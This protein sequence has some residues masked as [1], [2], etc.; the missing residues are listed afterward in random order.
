[1]DADRKTQLLSWLEEFSTQF[2][3]TPKGVSHLA[4]YAANRAEGR[5]NFDRAHA[6][7]QAGGDITD[8]VLDTL[9]PHAETVKNRTRGAWCHVAPAITGDIR[10]FFENAEWA[11]REDWPAIAQLLY[12]FFSACDREPATVQQR[13]VEFSTHPLRKGFK[14]AFLS[15]LLNALHPDLFPIVNKKPLLLLTWLHGEKFTPSVESYP[16]TAKFLRDLAA[17]LAEPLARTVAGKA[18]PPVGDVLDMFA[19]WLLTEKKYAA[20][21]GEDEP[22]DETDLHAEAVAE[23]APGHPRYWLFAA[24]RRAEAWPLFRDHKVVAI[25]WDELGDLRGFSSRDAL[26][27]ALRD[28]RSEE[29]DRD[30][31][32]ASL[33]CWEFAHAVSVGDFVVAKEGRDR[34]LGLGRV[35]GG[36]EFLPQASGYKHRL[37]VEW[38]RTGEWH[39]T[40]AKLPTKTLTEITDPE[41]RTEILDAINAGAAPDKSVAPAQSATTPARHW[42]MNFNPTVFDIEATPDGHREPYTTHNDNGRPRNLPAA[43][44]AAQPGDFVIGYSTAPRMRACVLC[45]ITKA[46][47]VAAG[48]EVIEFERVRALGRAVSREEMLADERLADVGALR[49]PR[50]SLFPLSADQFAAIMD[51]ADVEPLKPKIYNAAEALADLFTTSARLEELRAQLDRKKNLVLQGPPGV[52]KTFIARRLAWLLIGA[53]DD[54]R[55]EM[56]QFHPSLSYEDFVLGLRPGVMPGGQPGFVLRPGVFHRFCRRAQGDPGRPYVFIIDEINRGNLAKIFGELLML[57]E[58]DKR[59]EEHA[60]PLAYGG[61]EDGKFFLPANLHLIGTMNTADRSLALVDYALRRRFA[62]CDMP[63]EFGET[64][65]AHLVNVRKCPPEMAKKIRERVEA[66]NE[67]ICADTRSLGRGYQIGHSFFCGSE[68]ITDAARWYREIVEFEIR[69]LL[70]EYWVDDPKRAAD[71]VSRLLD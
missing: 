25:N 17:D 50:G 31:T 6:T 1:M 18:T 35:T 41:T 30:P 43:F 55:V 21:A 34:L 53:R 19:H 27:A 59:G 44:A 9:L 24:G 64:F 45:R 7:A 71:E 28:L 38:L 47:H 36:Y 20:D 4:K 22:A 29:E 56:V 58:A 12:G 2:A 51:L 32:N 67:I 68:K 57:I 26:T 23:V 60:V 5:R 39:L 48:E 14:T 66:L 8:L 63:P 70:E 65:F 62:F 54:T 42:W 52:G 40:D 37:P 49:N 13:C 46:K 10:V 33:A 61:E 15:P 11:R 3:Q 69:P 16:R